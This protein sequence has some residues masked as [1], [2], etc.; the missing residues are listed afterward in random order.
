MIGLVFAG[1]IPN[2]SRVTRVAPTS[3]IEQ[4]FD[5]Q[6]STMTARRGPTK[7]YARDLNRLLE[8]RGS[9]LTRGNRSLGCGNNLGT[10]S[11]SRGVFRAFVSD[12]GLSE[13]IS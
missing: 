7:G 1:R 2:G 5:Y 8:P 9:N 11:G 10:I 3:V 6:H 13:S 12:E 4:R